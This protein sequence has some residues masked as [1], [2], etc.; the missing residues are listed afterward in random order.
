MIWLS[1]VGFLVAALAAGLIVRWGREHAAVYSDSMPQRF[2]LGHVPRLGG[3]ALVMGTSVGWALGVLQSVYWGDPG[4][5]RLDF[6][7][8]GWLVVVLPAVIGG[9]AE[10]LTPGKLI[11]VTAE[12]ASGESFSFNAR[13]RLDSEIEVAYYQNGGILQY[14]LRDFLKKI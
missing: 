12:K 6:W 4:S 11:K 14:I 8:A 3:A 13:A 2:H 5:L 1:V 10:D 7:V 9:I